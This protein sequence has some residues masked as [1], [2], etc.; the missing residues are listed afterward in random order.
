[1]DEW[2]ET[3]EGKRSGNELIDMI[4]ARDEATC[5]KV[6]LIHA[7]LDA[8]S[9]IKLHHLEAA[10]GFVEFLWESRFPLFSGHG[11]TATAEIEDKIIKYVQSKMPL[12]VWYR[13]IRKGAC[14]RIAYEQF[15]RAM[16]S[17]TMGANPP[18]KVGKNLA[19]SWV[20]TND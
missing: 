5:R 9:E 8:S 12:G 18:L 4:T 20:W 7:A 16:K 15:E 2:G 1:M 10:I 11:M 19:K 3:V 17:L 6:A 14:Q 13:Q